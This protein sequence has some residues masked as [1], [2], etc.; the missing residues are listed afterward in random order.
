MNQQELSTLLTELRSH[1][2]ETEWIEF[3]HNHADPQEIGEYLSAISNSAALH[4]KDAAY[5]VW[6]IED[7]THNVVGTTFKPRQ[8]K[9][10]NEELEN[11]LLRLLAP[12]IDMKIHEFQENG[13]DVVMFE[14]QPAHRTPVAFS[15]TEFI[16]VGSIKKKL[17]EYPDKER[18]L[19]A[20][21]SETPFE[22]G[23]A[24]KA[25]SSNDVLRLIEFIIPGPAGNGPEE[26]RHRFP[27]H[28]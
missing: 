17:K 8:A 5:I 21:F 6:G 1:S 24:A 14:T 15:G 9:K 28:P 16:R 12:R 27:N 26:L 3:K 18:A 23:I 25:V 4:R 11:W 10:G 7:A 22:K 20:I 19:W 2:H 13:V